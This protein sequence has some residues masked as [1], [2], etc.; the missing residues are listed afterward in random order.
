MSEKKENSK[1]KSTVKFVFS[2]LLHLGKSLI[3]F[4]L[5]VTYLFILGSLFSGYFQSNLTSSKPHGPIIAKIKIEGLITDVS[6]KNLIE[7][8]KR[9][10]SYNQ[11]RAILLEINS[12]GGG[13]GATQEIYYE[14][15]HIKN[16]KHIPIIAYL[17]SIAASGG[18]YISLPAN[19]IICLPGTLTGSIGVYTQWNYIGELLKKWGIETKII[20]AGEYKDIFNPFSKPTSEKIRFINQTVQDFYNQFLEVV[21]KH[22]NIPFEKVK[23]LAEGKI[24]TGRQAQKL[25]LVDYIGD[26]YFAVNLA[27]KLSNAT[28]AK[29]FEIKVVKSPFHHIFEEGKNL[30][31]RVVNLIYGKN[32]VEIFY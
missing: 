19:K 27:K 13:I 11:T 29:V 12:P 6:A 5:F 32:G 15:L 8:L 22:R 2:P 3:Y 9:A 20:K 4:I 24:Y 14:L 16:E 17:K 25:G 21:S 31:K 30:F 18:Y 1:V 23:A 7:K 10:K 26:Y 28:D